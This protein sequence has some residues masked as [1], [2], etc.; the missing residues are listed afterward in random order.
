MLVHVYSRNYNHI[1]KNSI[2]NESFLTCVPA[3]NNDI[4]TIYF[5]FRITGSYYT[6]IST[7]GAYTLK[8]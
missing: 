6:V 7:L 4:N 2:K 1:H 8:R 3:K 5:P